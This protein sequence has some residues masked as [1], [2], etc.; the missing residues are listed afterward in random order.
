MDINISL[1]SDANYAHFLAMTIASICTNA[2]QQDILHFYIIDG[3]IKKYDKEK[4][5]K[6]KSIKEFTIEYRSMDECKDIDACYVPK[7]SHFTKAIY[8]RFFIADLFPTVEKIIYL[9]V[10]IV[11]LGS[12]SRLMSIDMQDYAIAAC[13]VHRADLKSLKRTG[14][15]GHS[16]FCSGVLLIDAATW[17]EKKICRQL[18]DLALALKDKILYGDQDV[19]NV[20]F[21]KNYKKLTHKYNCHPDLYSSY[22]PDILHFMGSNKFIFTESHLIFTYLEKAGYPIQ[23]NNNKQNIKNYI[24]I[25]VKNTIKKIILSFTKKYYFYSKFEKIYNIIR[26]ENE[27]LVQL[28]KKNIIREAIKYH[29]PDLTVKYGPFA[30]M[31]YATA[32]SFCSTLFP[33]LLGSYEKEVSFCIEKMIDSQPQYI[34]DIGSAEGYYSI[35]MAKALPESHVIAFEAEPYAQQ[36]CSAMAKYNHVEDRISLH[37]KITSDETLLKF[38]NQ[39]T[40][41]ICDIKGFEKNILTKRVFEYF[42]N[43]FFLIE[44]HD[45]F[46]PYTSLC[47]QHACK[48]SHSA[49]IIP[50][51]EDSNKPIIYDYKEI[52]CYSQNIKE[53]LLAEGRAAPMVWFFCQPKRRDGLN[54]T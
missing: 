53:V 15:Y 40:A 13:P 1:A 51:L 35:G 46:S 4:I 22:H 49:I 27:K 47:I 28:E 38:P 23:K 42:S 25:S 30:G 11:V 20:F 26:R 17:R 48:N 31:Q 45:N 32:E 36:L 24:K 52:S 19:L 33:K 6:L 41:I 54:Y 3:G 34:I 10:D 29:F 50:A 14:C 9:D 39:N 8:A 12:L 44:I 37:G 43:S 2:S 21:N 7:N 16:Y 18:L 5:N